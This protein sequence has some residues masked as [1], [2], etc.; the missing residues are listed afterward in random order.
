MHIRQ[1]GYFLIK[2]IWAFFI[3]QHDG[4]IFITYFQPTGIIAGFLFYVS[5]TK[6]KNLY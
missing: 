4:Y 2:N 1:A 3:R 5:D 6:T